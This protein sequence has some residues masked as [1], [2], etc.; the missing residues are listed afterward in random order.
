MHK[1]VKL[2]GPCAP[3]HLFAPNGSPICDYCS[4]VGHKFRSCRRR[5]FDKRNQRPWFNHSDRSAPEVL[6]P[7]L[8]CAHPQTVQPST[9]NDPPINWIQTNLTTRRLTKP[10]GLIRPPSARCGRGSAIDPVGA[11]PQTPFTTGVWGRNPQLHSCGEAAPGLPAPLPP[12]PS[13]YATA[14]R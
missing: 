12:P 7:R 13:D 1:I 9:A 10:A 3:G 14:R 2:R 11:P 6:L 8:R 4:K 5:V